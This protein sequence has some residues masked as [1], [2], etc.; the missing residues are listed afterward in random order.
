MIQKKFYQVTYEDIVW[1]GPTDGDTKV[2]VLAEFA[3]EKLAH[4][5][6]SKK[7]GRSVR[8]CYLDLIETI[9]EYSQYQ[10]LKHLTPKERKSLSL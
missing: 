9:D 3:D 4:E 7:S 2:C 8:T 6:A 10:T 1:Y 5:F